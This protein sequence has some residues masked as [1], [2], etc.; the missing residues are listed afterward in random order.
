[1]MI[2]GA[3]FDVDGTLLDSMEIWE[4]AA[5]RYLAKKGLKAEPD[6]AQTL[7][8]MTL[9]GSAEYLRK[10][11]ALSE[12]PEEIVRGI[13]GSV[14]EYYE[15]EVRLKEGVYDYLTQLQ[16]KNIPMTVA[17]SSQRS[18][19]IKAFSRLGIDGFFREICTCY[20]DHTTKN[21]PDIYY[22]AAAGFDA[23]PSEVLVF[24]DAVH[25][26]RTAKQAGFF[27]VGVYDPASEAF[28]AETER[29]CDIYLEDFSDFA[30]FWRKAAGR[31]L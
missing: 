23:A 13:V 28:R 4:S 24:E 8:T 6:L 3:I 15:K 1:M 2:R 21:E 11:Y 25:A 7:Y 29:I 20:D 19:L 16:A 9:N 17:T 10:T 14:E 22:R 5:S 26:V 27:T 12:A 31:S 18:Y 30:S